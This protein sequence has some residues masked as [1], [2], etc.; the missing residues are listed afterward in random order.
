LFGLKDAANEYDEEEDEDSGMLTT[1]QFD[2]DKLMSTQLSFDDGDEEQPHECSNITSYY[3]SNG[4]E[5]K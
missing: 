1:R 5:I 2:L 3:A 4:R